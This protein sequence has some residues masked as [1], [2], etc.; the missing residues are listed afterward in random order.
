MVHDCKDLVDP[1]EGSLVI[2]ISAVYDMTVR[3]LNF[4]ND[5][6]NCK[7][8]F[9]SVRASGEMEVLETKMFYIIMDKFGMT[10]EKYIQSNNETF[11]LPMVLQMGI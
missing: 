11:P 7:K 2:K 10:I 9:P 3:E 6:P 5:V 1:N 4:L 8:Q